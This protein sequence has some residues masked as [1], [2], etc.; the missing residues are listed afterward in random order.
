MPVKNFLLQAK[1]A[2]DAAMRKL[3]SGP[4]SAYKGKTVLRQGRTLVV[5]SASRRNGV[6]VHNPATGQTYTMGRDA[7]LSRKI[8]IV[9]TP[10]EMQ[11]LL[12]PRPIADQAHD[13]AIS[14]EVPGSTKI[15]RL[16]A[17]RKQADEDGDTAGVKAVTYYIGL[18][19]R[20]EPI[21]KWA[22][23]KK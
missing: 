1:H 4:V 20:G 16:Y 15:R 12:D 7:F 18:L 5:I 6:E 21:K 19:K 13:I 10:P 17:L 8:T 9:D 3:Q 14:A 2:V 22:P 11:R 23:D